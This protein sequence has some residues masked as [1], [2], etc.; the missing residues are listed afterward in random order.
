MA[1]EM[2]LLATGTRVP[3]EV[4]REYYVGSGSTVHVKLQARDVSG[5]HALLTVY[6]S[7]IRLVDLGSKNG[8]FHNGT[9]V[10]AAEV[11]NGDMVAFSSVKVQFLQADVASDSQAPRPFLEKE[12][13][14]TGEFPVAALDSDLAELLRSWDIAPERA[15]E[16]L[17][18]WIVGRRRLAGCALLQTQGNEVVVL[19]AQGQ[20]PS[21]LV[22]RELLL[23]VL[24]EKPR[25]PWEV[26]QIPATS[27]PAFLCP[28]GEDCSLLLVMGTTIPSSRELEL[29]GR[30]ARLACRLCG[31]QSSP[32]PWQSPNCRRR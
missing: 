13:S 18:S 3:L 11:V 26:R 30:L 10:Q 22:D 15:G 4:G 1:W 23:P 31:F 6:P 9:R 28:V 5:T 12:S 17:L 25:D 8:T 32:S 24:R 19:G 14:H 7:F 16:A 20:L 27:P 21:H 29:L 2:V